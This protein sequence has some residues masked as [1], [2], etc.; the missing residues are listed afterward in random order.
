MQREDLESMT[1][2]NLKVLLSELSLPVSGKKADLIERILQNQSSDA[3]D[4]E[5]SPE[6]EIDDVNQDPTREDIETVVSNMVEG[7]IVNEESEITFQTIV[8]IGIV[9]LALGLVVLSL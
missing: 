7:R 3:I 9:V 6:E 2:A 4:V 5:P 8:L 1:V